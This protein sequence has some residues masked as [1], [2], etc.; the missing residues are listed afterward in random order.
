[1]LITIRPTQHTER[2]MT[3]TTAIHLHTIVLHWAD[4]HEA[5][6]APSTLGAFGLGLR[7]YLARLEEIDAEQAEYELHQAAHLRSLERDPIQL[8]PRPV[9]IRLH[10][11][12][13]MSGIRSDLLQCADTIAETVMRKPIAPPPPR[14]AAYA[15]TRAER[16]VW[17]DHARRVQAAQDDAADQR[18]WRWT[19]VRPDAPYTALWLLGRVQGAPGP[20]RRH[21]SEQETARIASVARSCAERIERTL[22]IATQ[23]RT[24]EQ[25]HDECGGRIEVHGGDGARPLARCTGCGRIWTEGGVIAA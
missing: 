17:E 14:R 25:R 1:M 21:L 3:T 6:G 15:R 20:F 8:G 12:D 7:G 19:G 23:T 16:R 22:D 11:L 10:I 24:L 13:T 9:P 2:T 18:R 4:L 5:A